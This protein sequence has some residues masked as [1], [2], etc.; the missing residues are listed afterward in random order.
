MTAS[1]AEIKLAGSVSC[2]NSR[3]RRCV[4]GRLQPGT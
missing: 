4:P 3:S 2:G 1:L